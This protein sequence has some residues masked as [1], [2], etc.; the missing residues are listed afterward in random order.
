MR[1]GA[2]AGRPGF[3]HE[4]AFYSSDEEF[5]AIVA[6]F[7]AG[8]LA[9][10]EPT[11]A[12]FNPHFTGLLRAAPG[13]G[14]VRFLDGE[15]HYTRPATAIHRYR[16]LVAGL[17]AAGAEQVRVAGEVPHPGVG[18]PWDWWA[19]YEAVINHA[20]DELPLWGLCPYDVRICPPDVI[21][22]VRRTHPYV[23]NTAGHHPNPDFADPEEFLRNRPSAWRD[24]LERTPPR[25]HLTDPMPAE[26]RAAVIAAGEH[27]AIPPQ[28]LRGLVLAATEVVTNALVHGAPP[29]DARVWAAERRVLVTVA[30]AGPGPRSPLVG[31]RPVRTPTGGLGLW[32]AHQI[33]AHVDLRHEQ[34]RFTVRLL[35][36]S[37]EP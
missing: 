30:D 37:P 13:L 32:I 35:A 5:L 2:P 23:A 16:G 22:Q 6:P 12:A 15:E 3:F 31:L 24:P 26:L 4:A 17:V 10:G 8:G 7:L 29:V 18:V 1:S 34:G 27:S 14:G 21:A 19:R 20:Y 25:A 28:D 9:A 11:V 36:G 33:C